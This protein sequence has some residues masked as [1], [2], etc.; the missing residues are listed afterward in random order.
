MSWWTFVDFAYFDSEESDSIGEFDVD[1]I[2]PE[3]ETIVNANKLH[4]DVAKDICSLLTERSAEFKLNSYAVIELFAALASGF[5]K[6]SFAV[7]GSRSRRGNSGHLGSGI[8]GRPE[9]ICFGSA[10]GRRHLA[11]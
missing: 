6:I 9:H 5:P 1:R 2:R 4:S 3:I 7:R 8:F 10:R 11:L